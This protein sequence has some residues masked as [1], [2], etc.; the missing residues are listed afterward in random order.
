MITKITSAN[1]NNLNYIKKNYSSRPNFTL[2]FG[3]AKILPMDTL[4]KDAKIYSLTDALSHIPNMIQNNE[5]CIRL[6]PGTVPS[7]N[8]Q[9]LTLNVSKDQDCKSKYNVEIKFNHLH[10]ENGTLPIFYGNKTE[11]IDQVKDIEDFVKAVHKEIR[12]YSKQYSRDNEV[13]EMNG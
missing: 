6:K 9:N 10:G 5:K 2:S 3:S 11:L 13:I 7:G 8:L 12:E 1:I 4:I